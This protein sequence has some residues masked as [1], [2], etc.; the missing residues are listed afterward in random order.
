MQ[1]KAYIFF[2]HKDAVYVAKTQSRAQHPDGGG[3]WEN[4]RYGEG[5]QGCFG[6]GLFRLA[7]QINSTH[8]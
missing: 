4:Q 6:S 1:K 5:K 8:K 7:V 2:L 3:G